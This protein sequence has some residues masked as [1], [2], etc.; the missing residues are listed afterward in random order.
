MQRCRY[1]AVVSSGKFVEVGSSV[2][3]AEYYGGGELRL[4]EN[5]AGP[6]AA[7]DTELDELEGRVEKSLHDVAALGQ[8][9]ERRIDSHI[10]T[11]LAQ[12][13]Q[14]ESTFVMLE[15]AAVAASPN[16]GESLVSAAE[17]VLDSLSPKE[18][19]DS[20]VVQ[21][22]LPGGSSEI[23]LVPRQAPLRSLRSRIAEVLPD[24]DRMREFN[25]YAG[26][27]MLDEDSTLLQLGFKP[28]VWQFI[29]VIFQQ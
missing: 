17:R 11:V 23:D 13:R 7:Q 9:V 12:T 25:F 1:G 8:S 14:R 27:K 21:F 18:R 4:P 15:Y 2:C 24:R 20:F 16:E 26:E 6:C 22:V 10:L 19:H 29:H 5:P 3:S 28:Q